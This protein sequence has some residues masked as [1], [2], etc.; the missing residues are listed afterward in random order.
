MKEELKYIFANVNDWLKF[1]EAKHAGLVIL[2][3]ATIIGILTTFSTIHIYD[4]P[5]TIISATLLG[6]SIA[7]SLV[8]QF[9]Q[10]SNWIN[11]VEDIENPNL[12]FFGHLCKLTHDKFVQEFLKSNPSQALN[13]QENHLVNQ[14]LINAKIT[15]T[16]Y[17]L[18]KYCCYGTILGMGILGFS[19]LI[20]VLAN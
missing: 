11:K 15:A 14:I 20:K 18:F 6:L 7:C 8:A 17:H 2:N 9:P 10:T 12:Y 4:K 13:S 19:T 3:S 1:A 5:C 16:K